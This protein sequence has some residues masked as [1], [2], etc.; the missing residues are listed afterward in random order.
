MIWRPEQIIVYDIIL[1]N[2]CDFDMEDLSLDYNIYYRPKD[3]NIP[4]PHPNQGVK[5]GQLEIGRLSAGEKRKVES[6]S[7]SF[8][9][10]DLFEYYKVGEAPPI[11]FEGI[12]LR[13][14]LP[15]ESG[16]KAMREFSLPGSLKEQKTW[17]TSNVK[18]GMQRRSGATP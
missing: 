3:S 8:R 10:E 14:Y 12:R 2:R 6:L 9:M 5:Y 16:R 1:E 15:L 4:E 17:R 7:L 13:I 11:I 18:V